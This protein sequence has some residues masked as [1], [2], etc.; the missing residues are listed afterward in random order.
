MSKELRQNQ[1]LQL[2]CENMTQIL[3]S[4]N[5]YSFFY[6]CDNNDHLDCEVSFFSHNDIFSQPIIRAPEKGYF[7]ILEDNDKNSIIIFGKNNSQK[8]E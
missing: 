4:P 3:L 8:N 7:E 2:T 1:S 5:N 6:L